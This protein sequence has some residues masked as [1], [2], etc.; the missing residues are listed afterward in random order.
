MASNRI[1]TSDRKIIDTKSGMQSSPDFRMPEVDIVGY[2][3]V[4]GDD[5]EGIV[6]QEPSDQSDDTEMDVPYDIRIEQQQIRIQPDGS[7][8][9]DILASYIAAEAAQSHEVRISRL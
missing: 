8:V 3:T 7:A 4:V 1:N 2:E 9:V 5:G 6:G